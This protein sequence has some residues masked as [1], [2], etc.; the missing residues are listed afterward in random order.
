MILAVAKYEIDR[1]KTNTEDRSADK[2][3]I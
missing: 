2:S 1:F 3:D